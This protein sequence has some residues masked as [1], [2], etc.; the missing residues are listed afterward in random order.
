[1]EKKRKKLE[2]QRKRRAVLL[3]NEK[4]RL[5]KEHPRGISK[6]KLFDKNSRNGNP[7]QRSFQPRQTKVG[8]RIQQNII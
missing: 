2:K 8:E 6:W 5:A 3:K 1:L 4:I 7:Y